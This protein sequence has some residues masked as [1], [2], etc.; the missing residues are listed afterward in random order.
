MLSCLQFR[1][2]LEFDTGGRG[3]MIVNVQQLESG[4]SGPAARFSKAPENFR[5]RK[6]IFSLSVS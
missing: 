5:A 6:A 1:F 4:S 3:E 2:K